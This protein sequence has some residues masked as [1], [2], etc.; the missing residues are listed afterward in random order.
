MRTPFLLTSGP[1]AT[2]A[3]QRWQRVPIFDAKVALNDIFLRIET[4]RLRQMNFHGLHHFLITALAQVAA[5]FDYTH[6]V[7]T[8]LAEPGG[9]YARFLVRR[10]P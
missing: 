2:R 3:D 4:L 1:M 5:E 6:A 8:L 10:S 9:Q 7:F